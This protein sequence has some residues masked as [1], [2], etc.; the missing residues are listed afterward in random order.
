M[1]CQQTPDQVTACLEQGI[2]CVRCPETSLQEF[3]CSHPGCKERAN[4]T[5]FGKKACYDH[6]EQVY[7]DHESKG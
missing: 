4:V 5:I 1:A 6:A 7:L 3:M 2:E